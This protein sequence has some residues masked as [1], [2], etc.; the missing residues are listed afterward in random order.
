M[1]GFVKIRSLTVIYGH[2]VGGED[3]GRWFDAAPGALIYVRRAL[4]ILPLL[5]LVFPGAGTLSLDR[6]L[7]VNR[8]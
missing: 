4:W 6:L 8:A 3:L 1:I 2:G 5:T 7:A